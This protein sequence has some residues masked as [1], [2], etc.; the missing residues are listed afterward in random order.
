MWLWYMAPKLPSTEN[1]GEFNVVRPQELIHRL[2]GTHLEPFISQHTGVS[3][4]GSGIT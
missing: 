2:Y 3:G 1:G 4:K